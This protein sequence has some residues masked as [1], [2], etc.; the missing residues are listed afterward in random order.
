M[1]H[2]EGET[3][4][5]LL[6]KQLR[7]LSIVTVAGALVGAMVAPGWA[8]H[9]YH[10]VGPSSSHYEAI[11]TLSAAG[12]A[13]GF[14]DGY[15]RPEVPVTRGQLATLLATTAH[16]EASNDP[17]FEDVAPAHPHAHGITAVAEWELVR[18][19]ADGTYRPETVMS[20]GQAASVLAEAY[21]LDADGDPPFED[22]AADHPH[23]AGI[24]AA[25]E[26]GLASG[27]GDRTY[28]PDLPVS[29]GQL[30]TL[31]ARADPQLQR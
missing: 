25:A 16:M 24:A 22:V 8:Q 27:F 3:K 2:T 7:V 30:A 5:T 23:A 31:L 11:E 18:G 17:P 26:H 4:E 12:I 9:R 28:R 19:Y 14:E 10:D 6:R 29:R 21:R 15:F 1:F 13:D 20:R